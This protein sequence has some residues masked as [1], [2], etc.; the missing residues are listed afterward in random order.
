VK[1]CG[2]G[3]GFVGFCY[4]GYPGAKRPNEFGPNQDTYRVF[5]SGTIWIG[6]FA[7]EHVIY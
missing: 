6:R 7:P 3:E 5:C 4:T 1:K 2:R